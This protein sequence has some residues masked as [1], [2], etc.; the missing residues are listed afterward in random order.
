MIIKSN[1]FV[2]MFKYNF[3]TK[4]SSVIRMYDRQKD[5]TN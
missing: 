1:L 5:I 3:N 2:I 4:I